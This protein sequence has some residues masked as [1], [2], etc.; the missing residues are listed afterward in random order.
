VGDLLE[1]LK[2]MLQRS[3]G[4]DLSSTRPTRSCHRAEHQRSEN[5]CQQGAA[6]T[7][8][9]SDRFAVTEAVYLECSGF[10]LNSI[11]F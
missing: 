5:P 3:L 8:H 10:C 7:W 2:G 1:D 4:E 11:S 6:H 9:G